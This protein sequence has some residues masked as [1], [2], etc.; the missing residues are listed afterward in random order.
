M[1]IQSK[2]YFQ[3]IFVPA[4]IIQKILD[5]E[6]SERD[7]LFLMLVR[8]LTEKP[9]KGCYANRDYLADALG[10]TRGRISQ[11]ITKLKDL[12]LLKEYSKKG[13]RY[14]EATWDNSCGSE[15]AG[16]TGQLAGLT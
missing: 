7:L 1:N 13:T 4:Q 10:V 3:G 11:I 12:R 5:R 9:G 15:L 2:F 16:L 6:I 14:Y 8:G